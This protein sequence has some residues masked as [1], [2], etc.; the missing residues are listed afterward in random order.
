MISIREAC[1]PQDATAIRGIDTSFS[2]DVVYDVE[3]T[4]RSLSLKARRLAAPPLKRFPLDD[5]D[6]PKRPWPHAFVAEA[7]GTC[8]G[9]AAAGFEPWNRR[10]TLWHLYVD[11]PA[12]AQ[13]VGRALADRILHLG[14][15]L[16]ARHLW[17]ETSNLNAPGVA[18][19]EALGFRLT[20]IDLSLYDGTPAEGEVALFFSKPVADH[21]ASAAMSFQR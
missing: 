21:P 4:G 11:P 12:R 15:D 9:F 19:Y 1:L 8:L 7:E 6:D 14:H 10:L 18:V 20:G 3:T 13:G 5:L 2:T 16:G 17:L